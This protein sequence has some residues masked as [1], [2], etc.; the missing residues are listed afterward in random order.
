MKCKHVQELLP[1][2]AG[3]DLDEKLAKPVT[4]HLQSCAECARSAEQFREAQQLMQLL[5]PPPFSEAVYAGIRQRVLREIG[6]KSTAPTLLQSVASLFRPR[7]RWAAATALLLAVSVVAFYFIAGRRNDRQQVADSNRAVD[8]NRTNE[9]P[10]VP[11]QGNE[12]PVSPSP[13][14]EQSDGPSLVSTKRNTGADKTTTGSVNP[15]YQPQR[16]KSL[17]ATSERAGS[18][19]ANTPDRS[20]TAVASPES[21]N[22]AEPKAVPASDPAVSEKTLRVEMQTK[23]PNIRI[24][25]ISHQ[26]TKQDSL[27]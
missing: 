15:T 2:Y 20:M 16:R 11:S 27:K 3:R 25:W 7:I 26:R 23:D 1:L 8:Q 13:S 21:D 18:V 22:L 10:I 24:I 4:A 14:S 6:R 9:R 5:E 17:G 12:S 19:A